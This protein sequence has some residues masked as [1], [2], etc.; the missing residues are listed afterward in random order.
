MKESIAFTVE[1]KHLRSYSDVGHSNGY[2]ALPE[3]HPCYEM[4][5][6]DIHEKYEISV[7]GG[8][9]FSYMG[10]DGPWAEYPG[11]WI[12]GFDTCHHM[13]TLE[14]WPQEAVQEEANKLKAQLDSLTAIPEPETI[15]FD[16][17]IGQTAKLH[18]CVHQSPNCFQLGSVVFEAVEDE[19][20]GYRSMMDKVVIKQKDARV[21][22]NTVLATV[23]IRKAPGDYNT[24]GGDHDFAGYDLLDCSNGHVWLTFGTSHASDYYPSFTFNWT[25]RAEEPAP[26]TDSEIINLIKQ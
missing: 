4:G 13:D 11:M 23:L 3:G 22:E 19:N 20:D 12:V 8:L 1:N 9:T 18:L 24:Y 16:S 5:Y 14:R 2:V 6:D 7:H 10:G 15:D 25:P 21:A 26:S 17:L